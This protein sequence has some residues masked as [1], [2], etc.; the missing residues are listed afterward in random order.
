M[1]VNFPIKIT[2]ILCAGG[3]CPYQ[4][5]AITK[6][7]NYFYLRY[8]GGRLRAG[9]AKTEKDFDFSKDSYN[10]IDIRCGD[11]FDGSINH[12]EHSKLLEGKVIFP[13]G[14]EMRSLF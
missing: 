9:V 6:E 11:D 10:V 5:E 13:E 3:A 4:I 7:G 14:F 8:R 12:E 1:K 2:R